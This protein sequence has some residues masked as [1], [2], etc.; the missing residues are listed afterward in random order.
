M[1]SM[2]IARAHGLPLSFGNT[3]K[4][5]QASNKWKMVKI[6]W[7]TNPT[8]IAEL[9]SISSERDRWTRHLVR[10]RYILIEKWWVATRI[11]VVSIENSIKY[12]G[13]SYFA[14]ISET[15]ASRK[16]TKKCLLVSGFKR[17]RENQ[18]P[19]RFT[20]QGIIFQQ[21]YGRSRT[22]TLLTITLYIYINIL[23]VYKQS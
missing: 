17:L 4:P 9:R 18:M 8:Q 1:F 19:C 14:I 23:Y 3:Q 5:S 2:E 12:E 7:T 11:F 20:S 6:I 16:V 21:E 22:I 13:K 15:W 10:D